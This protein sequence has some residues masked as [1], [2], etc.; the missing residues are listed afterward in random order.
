MTPASRAFWLLC[1][2]GAAALAGLGLPLGAFLAAGFPTAGPSSLLALCLTWF[3]GAG[4]GVL[5]AGLCLLLFVLAAGILMGAAS[6]VRQWGR[7]CRLLAALR[8]IRSG[9]PMDGCPSWAEGL[10]EVAETQDVFALC[11]GVWRQRIVVTRGLLD[12]LVPQELEAVLLHERNHLRAGDPIKL[13]VARVIAETLFFVPVIPR[14]AR[15]YALAK[16]VDA[17][18]AA[19]AAQSDYLPMASAF[20][21]VM[22]SNQQ[23]AVPY[24]AAGALTSAGDRRIAYF[25]TGR[26]PVWMPPK[27]TWAASAALLAVEVWL[28]GAVGS[29]ADV[30]PA[31]VAAF[32]PSFPA[33]ML[34]WSALGCAAIAAA[35]LCLRF[36][37]WGRPFDFRLKSALV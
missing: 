18:R 24:A 2:V 12:I 21:K 32:A 4:E 10:V 30:G 35:I 31:R 14:L 9:R 28:A 27:R 13:L 17:D 6:L 8:S 1:L 19:I 20:C 33:Q 16:E 11:H 23:K 5:H 29:I 34:A 25:T 7:T 22:R 15:G 37:A 26:L 3:G 36:C